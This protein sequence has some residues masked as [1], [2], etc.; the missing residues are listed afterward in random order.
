M[1][2][3]AMRRDAATV[4]HML[5]KF[6]T[7]LHVRMDMANHARLVR[8]EIDRCLIGPPSN[9]GAYHQAD[10]QPEGLLLKK[11]LLLL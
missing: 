4:I 7:I 8:R 2:G 6:P 1:A 9:A 3:Y 5:R 10:Q 11:M